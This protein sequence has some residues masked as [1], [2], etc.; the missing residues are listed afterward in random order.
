[1]RRLLDHCALLGFSASLFFAAICSARAQAPPPLPTSPGEALFDEHCASCHA[2]GSAVE[3]APD[4]KTLMELTPESVYAAVTTGSMSVPAQPLTDDQKRLVA[5]YLGGRPLDLT[6]SAGAQSMPNRCASN[7]PLG[8]PQIGPS[9]NGWSVDAT[10]ARFA[11]AKIAGI[12]AQQISGLTLKWAF[13]FPGGSTAYGQPTVVGGRIY[14]GSDNGHVYSLDAATGC[15]YWSF[16]AKSGVRTSPSVGPVKGNGSAKYAVYFADM[17]ANA[18]AVDAATGHQ[19]WSTKVADHYTARITG[20]PALYQSRVYIP[21]SATEEVF[22][23]NPSYP[24]CTFRGSV[25]ALDANT[26]SLIWKTYVIPERPKPVAKNSHGVQRWA[27]AGAAVWN[28]PTI[29]PR[30]H[31]LYVGTGDAYTEP[32]AKNSDAIVALDL[33]T[34]NILW[35]FQAVPNDAW[36]VGC[37]PDA[38]ENCPKHLGVDFDFG[39]SPILLNMPSG[40][41]LLLATPKSGTVFALDPDRNGAVVWKLSVSDR[42]AP[43]NGQI[44]FGGSADSQKIYLALE[45]GTFVAIHHATG[46]RAWIVRLESLDKLGQST[47]NGE[48]RTKAGLRFGQSAAVTGVPGAVFTGGWDGILRALSTADGSVLWQFNTAQEF[49]TV[50]GVSA[51]GGSMG[52]PGPTVVNGMLYVGSGY[53]NV[54]G[55]MPGNVLLAFS[56]K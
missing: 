51:K 7:S 13:G 2:N 12:S 9:W 32:A 44:A 48:D 39:S 28:A 23:A 56:A 17:R 8:N 40:H 18:Y 21:V 22:S 19:L 16:L 29:D 11:S 42:I 10:N 20:A 53:A 24:C 49:K 3:R 5:E 33:E 27:P 45:D 54:G 36:M 38:T 15:V 52:G 47:N 31:A 14:V 46:K 35:S 41:R 55:G 37:V 6:D 1:M 26:G 43:N 30:R 34:G 25:V 4:L 50:N